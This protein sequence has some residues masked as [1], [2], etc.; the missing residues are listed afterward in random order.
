MSRVLSV[1][2]G[3]A[4]RHTARRC[5]GPLGVVRGGWFSVTSPSVGQVAAAAA[6]VIPAPGPGTW[7]DSEQPPAEAAHMLHT[8]GL[9]SSAGEGG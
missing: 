5:V 2:A 3:S 9:A 1:V 7:A 6:G 8:S 4:R